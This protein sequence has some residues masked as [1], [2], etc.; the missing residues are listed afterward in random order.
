LLPPHPR[1]PSLHLKRH[2]FTR[3]AQRLHATCGVGCGG[4][5]LQGE[6]ALIDE[7]FS[8]GAGLRERGAQDKQAG[9]L[10]GR[11]K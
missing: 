10:L 11:V 8:C 3:R 5:A 2:R 4:G 1:H 6:A 9:A 7:L